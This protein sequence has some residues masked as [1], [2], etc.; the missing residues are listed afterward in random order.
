MEHHQGRS[1]DGHR[2]HLANV[3]QS[4]NSELA[5]AKTHDNTSDNDDSLVVGIGNLRNAAEQNA[6]RGNPED[7][8]AAPS[9]VNW[10]C[11][12]STK[13]VA[14]VDRGCCQGLEG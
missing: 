14:N 5:Y 11:D 10:R 12:K 6:D 3:Q 13:Q 2:C 1:T 8:L 7:H 4:C 9:I